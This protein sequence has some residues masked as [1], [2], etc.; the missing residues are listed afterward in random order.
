[1]F[2]FKILVKASLNTQKIYIWLLLCALIFFTA[3]SE[4]PLVDGEVVT[5]T[6]ETTIEV[7]AGNSTPSE[8]E[9]DLFQ[10]INTV[11]QN[12]QICQSV[13]YT[14][15]NS[16]VWNVAL[17]GAA[18]SHVMDV[19]ELHAQGVINV[20][21]NAPPHEGSDGK[22]VDDRAESQ[23]YEFNTIAENLASASNASPNTDKVLSSWLSSTQGHCEVLVQD[24]LQDIGLY[25]ENGVWAAVFGEPK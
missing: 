13:F 3:C 16:L 22:R 17:A 4:V 19:L 21:T 8:I 11:R 7:L 5:P 23:G 12:G 6:V 18:K 10:K 14:K 15:S 9:E 25:F 1:M 2:K 20:R 24:N